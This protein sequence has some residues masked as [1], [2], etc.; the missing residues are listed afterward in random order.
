MGK[1]IKFVAAGDNHGDHGDPN[2]LAALKEF[3]KDFKPHERIHLGDCFDLR[4]W[5]KGSGSDSQEHN[6][7]GKPDLQEGFKMLSWYRPTVF[8]YGNHEDRITQAIINLANAKERDLAEDVQDQ[9]HSKLR[10]FGC[11]KIIKYHYDKGVHRIGPVA[12]IHGYAHGRNATT[13]QGI[14]YATPG[15]ALIHGHTHNLASEAL[16]KHGSGNAFSAGCLCDKSAMVY[17]KNRLATARWGS[18]FVA[19]IIDGDDYKA[20]LIHKSGPSGKW[21]WPTNFKFFSTNA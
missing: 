8:L 20:W 15:G 16:I 7:S 6:Q 12:F 2:A 1:V 13:Q 18:G 19:G 17:A 5:R 11:R 10:S 14:H 9:I 3:C 4:G 21:V